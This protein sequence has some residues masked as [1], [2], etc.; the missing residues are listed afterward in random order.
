M[1]C[2]SHVSTS[3]WTEGREAAQEEFDKLPK[4]QAAVISTAEKVCHTIAASLV[5]V[6]VGIGVRLECDLD[7]ALHQYTA[8]PACTYRT[9][10]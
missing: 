1:C 10:T 6:R 8:P 2:C 7:G 4:T 3:P 5:R 9:L